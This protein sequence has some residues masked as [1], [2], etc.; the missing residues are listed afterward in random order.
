MR[1][2]RVVV[3][4]LVWLSSSAR[5]RKKKE[6]LWHLD[7]LET[8]YVGRT[9]TD[10][11][12]RCAGCRLPICQDDADIKFSK[13]GCAWHHACFLVHL[14]MLKREDVECP[15]CKKRRSNDSLPDTWVV[16]KS[17]KLWCRSCYFTFSGS[18]RWVGKIEDSD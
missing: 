17:G 8:R 12:S 3:L 18:K 4:R 13:S 1:N 5:G 11:V 10:R 6:N 2:A 14:H 9:E 16:R 7:C 15:G